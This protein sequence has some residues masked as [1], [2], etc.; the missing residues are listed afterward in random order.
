LAVAL[1]LWLMHRRNK[2][3]RSRLEE[4]NR[5]QKQ[6]AELEQ[7]ALQAQMNPHFVF[8][9]LNSIQQFIVL[10]DIPAANKYLT[11]FARLIRQT[12]DNSAKRMLSLEEE[13]NYLA[14][15]LELEKMRFGNRFS[16][17]INVGNNIDRAN[18]YLPAMLIQPFVENSIRHGLAYVKEGQGILRIDFAKKGNDLICTIADNGIGRKEAANRKSAAHIEY[19]SK[20]TSLTQKRIDLINKT[21]Q[22]H[23]SLTTKD[24]YQTN[25]DGTTVAAGTEVTLIIP[26]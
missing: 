12:L 14:S 24:L 8:N 18:D 13:L 22:A 21:N 26:Q 1:A 2:V 11:A 25:A 19:Q 20:G 9:C 10:A 6:F 3:M 16:Y 4:K 15:Y 17:S 23:I 7:Q 5:T